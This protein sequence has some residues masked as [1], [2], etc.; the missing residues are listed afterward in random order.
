MDSAQSASKPQTVSDVVTP[1]INGISGDD[2][3]LTP[4]SL[5]KLSS[6]K[7]P[8]TSKVTFN[9]TNSSDGRK[10]LPNFWDD[11]RRMKVLFE[12]FRSREANPENWDSKMTF[13]KKAIAEWCKS[14]DKFKFTISEFQQAYTKD[15]LDIKIPS[16]KTIKLAISDMIRRDQDVTTFEAIEEE[17][18]S[19]LDSQGW[20]QWG[21]SL[22]TKPLKWT[23]SGFSYLSANA[24][25]E[26]GLPELDAEDGL[27]LH[28]VNRRT[29]ASLCDLIMSD[30]NHIT[31]ESNF[32]CITVEQLTE[33]SRA[34]SALDEESQKLALLYLQANGK[35]GVTQD[36]DHTVIKT[37]QNMSVFTEKDLGLVRIQRGRKLLSKEINLLET[38]L[39]TIK[40]DAKTYLANG[41]RHRALVLARRKKK[42]EAYLE[43]R[44][45]Q[46]DNLEYLEEQLI[47]AE[48]QRAILMAFKHANAAIKNVQVGVNEVEQVMADTEMV[49]DMAV[50][51]IAEVSRPLAGDKLSVSLSSLEAELDAVA[52]KAE[53]PVIKEKNKDEEELMNILSNLAVVNDDPNEKEPVRPTTHSQATQLN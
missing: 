28:L 35:V 33:G 48:S 20:T 52:T 12:D 39:E 45:T 6:P 47:E 14:E 29:L 3:K 15:D 41:N 24:I 4:R 17:L 19:K 9:S 30:I 18:K 49:T 53:I 44:E 2:A 16:A 36:S 11:N 51:A 22:L 7:S 8:P 32:S 5:R 13:W 40:R 50:D 34:Y 10:Y 25:D 37:G 26:I 31:K 46:M 1:R 27:S 42:L 21:V 38:E 23:V 43:Q